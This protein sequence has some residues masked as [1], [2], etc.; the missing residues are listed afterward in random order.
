MMMHKTYYQRNLPHIQPKDGVFAV[1]ICL[2]GSL[3]KAKIEALRDARDL[4]IKEV[5]ANGT[6][7]E[8]IKQLIRKSRALYFG[9]FDALLDGTTT[10]PTWLAQ[11]EIAR[12]VVDSLDFIN[13]NW[14]KVVAYCIMSNH[15]HIVLYKCEKQLF[16]ILGSMKR[17]TATR[18]NAVLYG[19]CP[20]GQEHPAFWLDESYDHLVR[21]RDD[22]S[23]KYNMY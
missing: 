12:I 23:F 11:P 17:Y 2:K 8:E 3:P 19:K 22:F 15:I 9:K 13:D 10:G 16:E 18:A 20:K 4:M 6:S 14:C 21:N 1:T 7:Q 5:E